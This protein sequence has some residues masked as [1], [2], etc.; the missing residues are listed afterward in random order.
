MD[1]AIFGTNLADSKTVMCASSDGSLPT[2]CNGVSVSVNGKA[3]PLYFVSAAEVNIQ[4]PVDVTGTSA[5][6]QLS[7]QTGGQT[8]QSNSF[9]AALAPTAPGLFTSSTGGLNLV[10]ATDP[11]GYLVTA[12]SPARPGDSVSIYGTGFGATNPPVASGS[13][14]PTTPVPVTAPVTATVGGKAATVSFAGLAPG[15]TAGL[16]QVVLKMPDGLTPGNVPV[17]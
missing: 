9:A 6:I 15:L 8:L 7:R 17:S 1:A 5:A 2:S 3:A 16:D 12:S 14:A 13:V 10:D 4:V 11:S